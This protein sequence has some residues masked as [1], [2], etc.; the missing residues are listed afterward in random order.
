MDTIPST[1]DG[2]VMNIINTI[3]GGPHDA[4]ILT[5]IMNKITHI[6]GILATGLIAY[7]KFFWQKKKRAEKIS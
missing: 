4:P 6:I 5:R 1:P 7:F 2:L 3:L